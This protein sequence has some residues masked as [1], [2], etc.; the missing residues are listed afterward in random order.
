MDD[1]PLQEAGSWNDKEILKKKGCQPDL[2]CFH[3]NIS[4]ELNQEKSKLIKKKE[5]NI[6]I[7]LLIGT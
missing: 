7:F 6:C 5:E 4:I 1:I 3:K 2:L